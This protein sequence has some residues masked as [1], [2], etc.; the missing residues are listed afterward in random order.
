MLAGGR[1]RELQR[2]TES[3]RELQRVTKSYKGKYKERQT[4]IRQR[5]GSASSLDKAVHVYGSPTGI[6][7]RFILCQND[8]DNIYRNGR[9]YTRRRMLHNK[10]IVDHQTP[11]MQITG[12]ES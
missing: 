3:Y 10:P 1:A 5:Y 4:T 11:K 6:I 8:Q 7:C 12:V 9:E 2:V